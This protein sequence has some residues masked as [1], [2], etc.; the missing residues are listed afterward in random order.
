VTIKDRISQLEAAFQQQVATRDKA[1]QEAQ[2][3]SRALDQIT[4]AISVLRDI[5]KEED[6]E[7]I[8]AHEV[9]E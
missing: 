7:L 2:T 8:N 3:A 5:E 6:S 9:E 1:M 4:G